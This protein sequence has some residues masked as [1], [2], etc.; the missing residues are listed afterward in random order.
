MARSAPR[1]IFGVHGATPYNRTTGLPYGELRV[2][3]GSSLSLQGE[4]QELLGGAAKYPWAVE[5]GAIKAELS[6]NIGQLEDFMFEL[7]LGKAPTALS[8]ETS[9]NVSTAANKKG[10][11]IINGSNGI[12]GV[13]ATSA[14]NGDLK[15][16]KYIIVALS[17]NTFDVYITSSIDT[18]RGNNVTVSTDAMKIIAA[19]DISSANVVDAATGLTFTKAGTP[20]FT[21][22]DTA[23]FE[24]RPVNSGGSTVTI[25]GVVDQSFPEFGCVLY[26]QKRGNQEMAE[27]DIFRC[28]AAGMP[29]PFE[30]GAFA[31]FE[32]KVACLYDDTQDGLF[33]FRHV[34]PA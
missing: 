22:G 24:V 1:A 14:D 10:T 27:I 5:E 29:I 33:S 34:K 12:S 16:G 30:M 3:K 18:G 19:A 13:S 31:A 28:K 21:T 25:G 26:A 32:V 7:F 9:G 20:A 2:L 23:T 4:Q 17:A 8:A 11:S 6:L 15:F